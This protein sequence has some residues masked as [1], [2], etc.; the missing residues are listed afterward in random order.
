MVGD[1]GP[2]GW[3]PR[4]DSGASEFADPADPSKL[5]RLIAKHS[6]N[7]QLVVISLPRRRAAMAPA[8]WMGSVDTMIA[9]L[10]RVILVKE[11][12]QE[13]VQFFQ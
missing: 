7:A 4:R 13:K 11:S 5:T 2:C 9:G 6:G 1:R 8:R 3:R 10:R 12:G